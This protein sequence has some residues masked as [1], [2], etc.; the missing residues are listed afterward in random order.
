MMPRRVW[1]VGLLILVAAGS[2]RLG[3]SRS[4]GLQLSADK[5]LVLK[6]GSDGF[7][8]DLVL[9]GR[10]YSLD[11]DGAV[12]GFVLHDA[13]TGRMEELAG[14]WEDYDG[15]WVFRGRSEPLQLELVVTIVP[16]YGR[17]LFHGELVDLTGRDRAVVVGYHLPVNLVGGRFWYDPRRYFRVEAG[18]SYHQTLPLAGGAWTW[19]MP[20]RGKKILEAESAGL[21]AYGRYN[22]YPVVAVTIPGNP[23]F[24]AVATPVEEPRISRTEYNSETGGLRISFDL[25]L[26]KD[27]NKFP[28]RA[29]F[30]FDLYAAEIPGRDKLSGNFVFRGA[31]KRY[32]EIYH[33]AFIRRVKEAG[34]WLPFTPTCKIERPLDF[35]IRFH[36]GTSSVACDDSLGVLSFRYVEPMSN[37]QSMPRSVPRT[38]EAA[39][40]FLRSKLNDRRRGKISRATLSCGVFDESG[41]YRVWMRRT[42]WSDGALFLLNPDPEIPETPESPVNKAHLSYSVP[43]ADRRYSDKS[44]GI[45]D[46][47]YIDSIEGW[48]SNINYRRE[49]FACSDFPLVFD[50]ESKKVGLLQAFSNLEFIR[51]ESHDVHWRG[52]LMMANWTPYALNHICC[53]IDVNGSEIGYRDKKFWTP[54]DDTIQLFRRSMV[55]NKPYLLLMNTNFDTFTHERVDLYMRQSLFYGFFPSMFSADASRNRY[56]ENPELYN[57]D[58]VLFKKYIPLIRLLDEAGW[59]PVTF[60]AT[61]DDS[62]YCERFGKAGSGRLYLTCLNVASKA[63]DV[64][65]RID[66]EAL[67]WKPRGLTLTD[68]V[69][70]EDFKVS[71]DGTVR[72]GLDSWQ[73]VMFRLE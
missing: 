62:V 41:R 69:T 46:G 19:W 6:Y 32:Y 13:A 64:R 43:D 45:L 9:G 25:G 27:T 53:L 2:L 26:S 8:R 56:F 59:E 3:C 40:R 18:K 29:T 57:R 50:P 22:L 12:S 24:L 61:G 67:H 31:L 15:A 55:Y 33:K 51:Y 4:S 34:I 21:Q 66:C 28:S 47:E 37:W 70:G 39:L 10:R 44:R 23:C 48:F 35:G 71:D 30:D 11:S 36:E 7:L 20:D 14:K 49:H 58:R 42:P 72:L 5:N 63:R 1:K 60:A 54:E 68:L 52:K 73:V 65:L 16:R 38:Y 17:L